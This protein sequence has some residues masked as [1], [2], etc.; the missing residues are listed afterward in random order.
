MAYGLQIIDG[1]NVVV[2]NEIDDFIRVSTQSTYNLA[3]GAQM[4]VYQAGVGNTGRYKIL[5]TPTPSTSFVSS[6]PEIT[7]Y[8]NSFILRNTQTGGFAESAVGGV[9]VVRNA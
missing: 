8:A 3:P 5:L 2:L 7:R 9:I 6:V 4:T 1:D